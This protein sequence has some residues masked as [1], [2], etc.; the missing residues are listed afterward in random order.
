MSYIFMTSNTP[1]ELASTCV[2]ILYH[3]LLLPIL[4]LRVKTVVNSYCVLLFYT[5]NILLC[6]IILSGVATPDASLN[7]K[8]VFMYT[9]LGTMDVEM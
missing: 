1:M 3:C 7:D 9:L 8:S 4:Y 5:C 6:P 2:N